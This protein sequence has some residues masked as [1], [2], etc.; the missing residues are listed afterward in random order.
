MLKFSFGTVAIF[1]CFDLEE[2]RSDASLVEYEEGQARVLFAGWWT[3]VK[4]Q[5]EIV[6]RAMLPGRRVK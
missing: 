6:R 3:A 1:F 4:Q 2:K 5:D